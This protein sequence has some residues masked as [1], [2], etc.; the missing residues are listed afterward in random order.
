[1]A[2]RVLG[3]DAGSQRGRPSGSVVGD[4]WP[5]VWLYVKQWAG[6][7]AGLL[8]Q[9]SRPTTGERVYPGSG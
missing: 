1:M 2:D 5:P 3:G 9:R 7:E 4:E 6:G 8:F